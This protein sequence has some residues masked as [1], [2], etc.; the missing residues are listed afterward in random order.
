M[1]VAMFV[2]LPV[3]CNQLTLVGQRSCEMITIFFENF[4]AG[5]ANGVI[6]ST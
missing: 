6:V 5:E 2:N 4:Q 3:I 1:G